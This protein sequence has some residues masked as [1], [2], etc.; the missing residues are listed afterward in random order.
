[1]SAD[2]QAQRSS[3]TIQD[4]EAAGDFAGALDLL[5][6][7]G[8]LGVLRRL[9]PDGAAARLAASLAAKPDLISQQVVTLGTELAQIALGRSQLAPGRKD[10][11]FADPAW[12][13]N[14]LLKRI[15]Q[16]YLAGGQ[17][18]EALLTGADL[19]WRDN[20]RLQ[21]LLTN[22]IAA[23]APSNNPLLSPQAVKAL[24]DSGGVSAVRG[25][26][27]LLT[28]LAA[29]PRV[30]TMVEPDAFEVGKDLAVTP[31]AVV[32]R[33][34]M[35]E[36]IQYQPATEQVYR[37]PLLIVPPM[38]NKY[39]L[40]D[41]APG[42]SMVEYLVSQG[43]QVFAIS[44][45]NPDARHADWDL[46]SYGHAIIQ[47]MDAT[48]EVAGAPRV[49]VCALCSGGIVSSMVAAHLQE[50]GRLGE[51]ASFCLGVTVLD[52]ARAGTAGAMIDETTANAA[53]AVS[54]AKGYLDGRSLA[55]VFAWLRPDDLIWNYWVNNYL[56][57]KAPP[58]F[59]ILAWN[60]DT[61][62]LPA[63]LHAG[64]IRLALA[65]AL[66]VP[67]AATMLGS[68][69]DLSKVDCRQLRDRGHRRSPVPVAVLL[70]DHAA[71]R[72]P[73]DVRAVDQRAHRFHGEPAG[74]PEGD[75]PDRGGESAGPA[76]LAC[77]REH[78]ERQLVAALFAVAG[79]PQRRQA[80][81]ED[82]ARRGRATRCC[83]PLRGPM[84]TTASL[85]TVAIDGQPIRVAVRPGLAGQTGTRPVPLL[86]LNGIGASL[87]LLT[88]FVEAL[89]PALEVIRFD[90]P[91][92]GGSPLPAAPYRFTGL[93][94]LAARLLTE[95]GYDEAD[96]LGISWGGGVAQHFAFTQRP[97]C[98]RL[99]LVSTGTG[100]LMVPARPAVLARMLTPRRYLDRRYLEQVARRPVRRQRQD[101]PGSHHGRDER[102]QPRRVRPAATCTSWRLA[103]AGPACR[104]CRLS[105][106]RR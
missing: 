2:Q 75:V 6:A 103:P 71:A 56:Q 25:L 49:S 3:Q 20:E 68:P 5:L 29:A 94:R 43:H 100:A 12:T 38:I 90:V 10:R 102:A 37:N 7:D 52:Q 67:D 23:A 26:R 104:S 55:E 57:G 93:C 63:A 9:R 36:L 22:L 8:A 80:Q 85:R 105:G 18:A 4:E 13:Q 39:Y 89:D 27:A 106:S 72:R 78:G 84:F 82:Q 54:R 35:F 24:L 97:R 88:P 73:G 48:R 1:M 91:G 79:R 70:P 86:V 81:G 77:G 44:W 47:A 28:D 53:M 30:P 16:A 42:R 76:R 62:R 65:N 17:T 83:V 40:I 101:R 45:R 69:V 14:P 32:F 64:F 50:A 87:E 34:E 46:D 31:G 21:F 58:A 33:T 51:V 15:V 98:R 66:T 41:L 92:V 95:L 61:T 19:E 59:D 74:Q 96:V 11:R 99:V 60:A